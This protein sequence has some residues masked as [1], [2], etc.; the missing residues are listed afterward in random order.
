MRMGASGTCFLFSLYM[1]KELKIGLGVLAIFLLTAAASRFLFGSFGAATSSVGMMDYGYAEEAI[2]GSAPMGLS[3]GKRAGVAADSIMPPVQPSSAS[4]D[5][6]VGQERLI[7][8]NGQ[9][10]MVVEDVR[11]GAEWI[12]NWAQQKGGFLVSSNIY[13]EYDSPRADVTVRVPVDV[14]DEGVEE[15]KAVGEVKSENVTGRDVTE[16]FV[17]LDAQVKNLKAT[18]EQFLSIMRQATKIADVLAVQR[19]L[20]SVR[21]QIDRI[22]G[23]MNYLQ[24]SAQLSTLTV[25]LSTDPESLPVVDEDDSWKPIATI[26]DAARSLVDVA[27]W[28]GNLVIWIVIFIPVWIALWL[29]VRVGIRTWERKKPRKR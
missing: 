28:F 5:T 6:T 14:F 26:K 7:I 24:K 8:K 9:L 25:H 20:T 13:D 11:A 22:Q 23:R 10:S 3:L 29:L 15:L 4:P 19:E 18:E 2:G 12:G 1:K 16:E 21:S 27:K 17:D